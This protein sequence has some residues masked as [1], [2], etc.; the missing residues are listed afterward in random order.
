MAGNLITLVEGAQAP[1]I[2]YITKGLI[3]PLKFFHRTTTSL[4]LFV[5]F[6]SSSVMLP[7]KRLQQLLAQAVQMQVEKCPFHY[8]EQDTSDYSLLTDH[9]CTR[10]V[11][12]LM[13]SL[14]SDKG[15]EVVS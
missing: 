2:V 14:G 15:M 6:F 3:L 11:Y 1:G 13:T 5:G 10:L 7:P 9:I 8:L 4:P 12:L